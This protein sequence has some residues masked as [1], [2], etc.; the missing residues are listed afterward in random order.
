MAL[1]L[2]DYQHE[3]CDAPDDYWAEKPDGNP[4][5][6]LP[7]GGGKSLVLGTITQ[8]FIGF[9]PT[10]RIV[11]TQQL[12]ESKQIEQRFASTPTGGRPSHR[13]FAL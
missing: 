13:W 2:R 3:A 6:V 8:E 12:L 5:I 11:I 7:T 4:L 9:E 1:V 10:T